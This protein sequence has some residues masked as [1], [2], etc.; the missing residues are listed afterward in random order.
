[1]SKAKKTRDEFPPKVRDTVAKRA[2]YICSNPA[3]R[4]LTLAAA[5]ADPERFV[6]VGK[7]AHI[8][9]AAEG[10]PRFDNSITPE[11]RSSI[12]NAIFLCSTCADLID[13][14]GG[15]D[16][17]VETLR[18][19]RTSHEAWI[20]DNLNKSP[21][22][23]ITTIDGQ[24]HASGI[25]E[26]IGVDAQGPTQFKPGTVVTAEGIG[27]VTATRTGGRDKEPK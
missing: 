26:V 19:W 23:I 16:H 7:A 21:M 1:M 18:K 24:H 2:S 20:R 3:C 8:T 6:F 10:G 12:D 25:G 22:S 13:R 27:K 17:P 14:N 5:T 11:V 4:S 9:A 15:I